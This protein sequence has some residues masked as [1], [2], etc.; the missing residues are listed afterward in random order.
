MAQ[1]DRKKF[2]KK[3]L[4]TYF[5]QF[6]TTIIL[7]LLIFYED[8]GSLGCVLVGQNTIFVVFG[9]P[10]GSKKSTHHLPFHNVCQTLLCEKILPQSSPFNVEIGCIDIKVFCTRKHIHSMQD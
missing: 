8:Y 9:C 1:F 4:M 6:L 2:R 5:S 10:L 3:A 7:K